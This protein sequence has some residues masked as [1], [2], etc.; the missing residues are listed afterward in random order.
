MLGPCNL[1]IIKILE[2][3]DIT[4]KANILCTRSTESLT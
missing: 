2:Y 4:T 1:V 3:R